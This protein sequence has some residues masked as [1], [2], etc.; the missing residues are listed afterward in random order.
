[1]RGVRAKLIGEGKYKGEAKGKGKDNSNL[2][3]QAT[4]SASRTIMMVEYRPPRG[5]QNII[6][7]T[8]PRGSVG[9]ELIA[10]PPIRQWRT[11]DDFLEEFRPETAS[12]R[13]RL[14]ALMRRLDDDGDDSDDGS[15]QETLSSCQQLEREGRRWN[16]REMSRAAMRAL[17]SLRAIEQA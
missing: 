14:E 6:P 9:N 13:R 7:C 16:R 11:P 8:P 2:P 3:L 15:E 4:H 1:M 5:A 12:K 17:T 10:A